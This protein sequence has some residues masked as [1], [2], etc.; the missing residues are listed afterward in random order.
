V[1]RQAQRQ[2]HQDGC[3]GSEKFPGRQ[4]LRAGKHIPHGAHGRFE[5]DGFRTIQIPTSGFSPGGA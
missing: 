3:V 5:K 1:I 4:L 2:D